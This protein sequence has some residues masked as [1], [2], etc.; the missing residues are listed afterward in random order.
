MDFSELRHARERMGLSLRDVADRTKI[1]A[2]ILDAIDNNDADRLPPPIFARGFVKAYARE[3]GL[4]PQ[5]V[6]GRYFPEPAAAPAVNAALTRDR[7]VGNGAS[8]EPSS[9]ITTLLIVAVGLLFIVPGLRKPAGPSGPAAP[10]VEVATPSAMRGTAIGAA[11]AT[12]GSARTSNIRLELRPQGPCWVEATADGTRVIYK[13]LNAGD[14]YALEGFDDLVLK[15]GDPAVLVFS[16]DGSPG[17]QL[18]A[19]GQPATVHLTRE[20]RR[21]FVGS[22]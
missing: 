15:V 22:S 10:S 17:R 12:T 18:G 14:R 8:A 4:D 6:A 19:A 9:L 13:L 3:V 1:R 16:I 20:N 11:V 7:S 5:A 21:Q 2:A